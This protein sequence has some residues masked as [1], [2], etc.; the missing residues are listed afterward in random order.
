MSLLSQSSRK[1]ATV[2]VSR[3]RAEAAPLFEKKFT[4]TKTPG[5]TKGGALPG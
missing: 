2:R 5:S 3:L 1:V 4:A